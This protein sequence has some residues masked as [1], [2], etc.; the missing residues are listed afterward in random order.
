[1]MTDYCVRLHHRFYSI[2]W[3]NFL[4]LY[5][6]IK[7]YLNEFYIKFVPIVNIIDM[8]I[9]KLTMPKNYIHWRIAVN[10]YGHHRLNDSSSPVLT[11][12][13]LS[14][15]KA[16]NSTPQ[17]IKTPDPIKIKFG[18]VDYIDEGTR[19]A[20]FYANP[21]KGG[22]PANGWNIRKNFYSYPYTFFSSTNL[23]VRPFGGFLRAMAQTT[24]SRAKMCLLGVKK[25]EINI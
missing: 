1:M 19:H 9:L 8:Q 18:T 6:S 22:F 25:F 17:R 2:I 20:K 21:P 7:L 10:S 11:A 3:T 24:R 23:Q 5:F 12:T 4:L 15:G 14:C 13:S 16:K